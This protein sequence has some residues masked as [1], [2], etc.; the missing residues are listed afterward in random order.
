MKETGDNA[1]KQIG[2]NCKN[3]RRDEERK[4]KGKERRRIREGKIKT[5]MKNLAK[6]NQ[7]G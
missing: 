6:I 4:G 1:K 7:K 2:N 5:I 3:E